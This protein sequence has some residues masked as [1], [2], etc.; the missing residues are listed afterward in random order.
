MFDFCFKSVHITFSFD[1][2]FVIAISS[3]ETD[4]SF[5]TLLFCIIHE[6]SHLLFIKIFDASISFISFYGGGIK[7]KS[8][9]V[10]ELSALKKTVIYLAGATSNLIMSLLFY[11]SGNYAYFEINL[12]LACFNLLPCAYLDGGKILS[13][14]V[15]NEKVCKVISL[16]T[17]SLLLFLIFC[18]VVLFK[19][20]FNVS[21]L[22]TVAIILLSELVSTD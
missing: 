11:L 16:F 12:F 18:S 2:F 9:G 19:N 14:V 5:A 10:S 4:N 20:E 21:S 8:D 22:V 15:K 6:L 1:F 13:L 7:I 3:L 17:F